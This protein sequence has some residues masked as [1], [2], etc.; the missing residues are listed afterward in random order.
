MLL[1]NALQPRPI[2][3]FDVLPWSYIRFIGSIPLFGVSYLSIVAIIVWSEF[4]QWY[5]QQIA[6]VSTDPG[7]IERLSWVGKLSG[8]PVSR[9]LG[10]ILLALILIAV[11]ATIYKFRCPGVVAETTEV[12]WWRVLQH[13]LLEYRAQAYSRIAWRW[14][15]GLTYLVGGAWLFWHIC[16]RFVKTVVYLLGGAS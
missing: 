11:G 2:R 9:R 6:S 3:R 7:V 15:S 1:P 14:A 4:L 12:Y 10:E 5:N 16:V 13:E 8:I